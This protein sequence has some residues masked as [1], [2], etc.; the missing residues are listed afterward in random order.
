MWGHR[1]W[2][3]SHPF[4]SHAAIVLKELR[5]FF[6]RHQENSIEFWECPSHCNWSLHKVVNKETKSFNPIL[7]FPCKL[8]W[9][10]SKKNKCNNIANR[11]KMTFQ[12]SDLKGKH[13][14]DL[15]DSDDN[16]IELSYI[17]GG[18]WLKHFSHSNSL[19]AR[20]LRV[21]T[22]YAPVGEYRLRFFPREDF[23]C[24]YGLYSIESRRHILHECRRFNEY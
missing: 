4:Q 20:A 13:F 16:I 19:C 23:S 10:F 1:T 15:L 6:S 14:L 8:S 7:L 5:T 11:W 9:D 21:I 17:K 12:A 24:P 18:S 3:L 22:N 2:Q